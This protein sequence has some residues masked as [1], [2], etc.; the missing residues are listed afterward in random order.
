MAFRTS[1]VYAVIAAV[2]ILLSDKLLAAVVSDP[3]V[4]GNWAVFKGLLFVAVTAVLLYM[5]LRSQLRIY[6]QEAAA[7]QQVEQALRQK[8][9][10][11]EGLASYSFDGILVVNERGRKIVQ[12]PKFTELM[13]IP[14]EIAERV[15][16]PEQLQFVAGLT[17]HPEQ[18]LSRVLHLNSHPDETS[19][20]EI[21]FKDGRVIDRCSAPI[22]GKDGKYHGRIWTFHDITRRKEMEQA[23][24]QNE[25]KFRALFENARDAIFI[26]DAQGHFVDVNR[27]ACERLQYK[28]EELLRMKEQ[29]INTPISAALIQER[30]NSLLRTGPG[31]FEAAHVCRNGGVIPVE[32]N[33]QLLQHEGRPL[34]LSCCRDLTERK[35]AEKILRQQ[36]SALEAAA[37]G[38]V[39]TGRSGNILWVNPAFERLTGYSSKE[40]VGRTSALL[41]SGVHDQ[42]FYKNL[43]DTILAG[44]VWHGEL[45]NRRKDG[46]LYNEE[47]TITPVRDE[48]GAIQS[49][50]AIKQD[51]T[52]R[53]RS[54]EALRESEAKFHSLFEN[55][56]EGFAC[57]KMLFDGNLPKDFVYLEVNT[58]FERLTGLKNVVGKK[59]S[60]VIP[61]IQTSNPELLETYG[62][63][64]STG[65][66]ERIEAYVESL[67]IWFSIA[68][69]SQEK[70]HF[71]AVF[72]NITER[73]RME[74]ELTRERDLWRTLLDNSPDKIYFKDA[75]SR[76]IKSS[77]AHARQFGLNSADELVGKTDFDFFAEAHARPAFED[78]Q[79]IIRTGQPIIAKEEREVWNDGHVT[80]ASSTKMP[81]SDSSGKITGIM[82]ITRDI[83]ERKEIEQALAHKSDLLQALMDNLPDHIYFKDV[84]SRFIYINRAHAKHLGLAKPEDAVGKCDADFFPSREGRQKLVDE[85]CLLA[86]GKPILGLIEKAETPSETK[87]VSS[88]K[89]P[90][91]GP[92]GKI[93][94]LVGISRD[95]TALKQAELERQNI[96]LQLRQAQKL[97]AIGQL[98]AGIAHE[99]NTPT[100]YVGDNTRFLKDAFADI[101]KVL[102]SHDELLAAARQNALTPEMLERAGEVLTASDLDYLFTQ[103]PSAINETL[104]GVDRVTKIVRAMK[105]FSHP[106][107]REKTTADLNK[108]IESTVTVARNEWK[109]VAD[110]K[111]ELE[112]DLPLV[113]C[114]IGEFNQIIL[115]LVV[116]ASH[117]IGDMVKKNPGTKGVITVR[118]HH[119]GDQVEVRISD[120]GTGIA[121]AHRARI[122]EPFFTTKDVG[123]GTGQ[124]LALVYNS[125]VKKHGGTVTFETETGKGTTFIIRLPISLK[126]NAE[127]GAP[128]QREVEAG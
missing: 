82:G 128:V 101:A 10:L 65:K 54:E 28:R 103:I 42:A 2:W 68:V 113:P 57:C 11:F 66:P 24:Q 119:D 22:L 122:F 38:I 21:E 25:S 80:W 105:E 75:Q 62:R 15:D 81:M 96:D 6:G 26:V 88:T 27:E 76:F 44:N 121:E 49:F 102:H 29:D 77:K 7:R 61:G 53:K 37:S 63:V 32:I 74:A 9:E 98:A 50:I 41:K 4:M 23:L 117:T 84:N 13:K 43:W 47:M 33:S 36:T 59:V 107:G 109:Y 100:Q 95:I 51:I 79:E 19:Q 31:I 126:N 99:I 46:T 86:T 85:Q 124:G 40:V 16:D 123:C 108:A 120:T 48:S 72:D 97:E 91:Y 60:E 111:L 69:Y 125:V 93:T 104:E 73:K 5:A 110:L 64:A 30:V 12:N 3:A 116:N 112:P 115:N 14:R 18:F 45:V 70:G 34:V 118:T 114:F 39:I 8:T 52:T 35:R 20:D 55:M 56:P 67:G 87:W 71:V 83:T 106:G 90:L 58:A 94:G 78:E 1:L 89:V 92:D 17:K 127:A